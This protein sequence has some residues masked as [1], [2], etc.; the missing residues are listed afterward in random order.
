MRDVLQVA[1]WVLEV[2][3]AT[4]RILRAPHITLKRLTAVVTLA[5]LSTFFFYKNAADKSVVRI[6]LKR[7][8]VP[9]LLFGSVFFLLFYFF[10]GREVWEQTFPSDLSK[11]IREFAFAFH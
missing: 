8:Q 9:L 7:Y 5:A 11:S 10:L 4:K 1:S 3:G 6:P 2:E